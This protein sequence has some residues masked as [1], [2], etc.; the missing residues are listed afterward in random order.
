MS[1]LKDGSYIGRDCST[2]FKGVYILLITV[3]HNYF[4]TTATV[5][6]EFM[7]W[8]YMFHIAGFFIL[9]SLYGAKRL[10]NSSV[11]TNAVRFL[12]PYFILTTI[13]YL[14]YHVIYCHGGF[15]L[16]ELLGLLL[17]CRAR[18][19]S[20]LC[21]FQILWFMPAMFSMLLLKDLFFM[22][23]RR[24]RIAMLTFT[25]AILLL[26]SFRQYVCIGMSWYYE[27]MPLGLFSG[28]YFFPIAMSV[29]YVLKTGL[30]DN[31]I[32]AGALFTAIV[33]SWLYFDNLPDWYGSTWSWDLG[34]IF[35]PVAFFFILW[36]FR[37]WIQKISLFTT[38]GE[39]SLSVY[40]IHP[41]IGFLL[42]GLFTGYDGYGTMLKILIISLTLFAIPMISLALARMF[43]RMT[44]IYNFLL[45]R[46]ISDLNSFFKISSK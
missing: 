28:L 32:F 34:R 31:R 45:P 14:G 23:S 26:F 21:G 6:V 4:F 10:T 12:W 24:W 11:M 33:L 19:L 37:N 27:Y 5:S 40:L 25:T 7:P 46:K 22:L 39:N 1:G 29:R 3:G 35:L 36:R 20:E 8:L 2:S 42:M 41:F 13:F 17:F 9:P 30:N 43:K 15:E 38:F 44:P 18:D 16:N